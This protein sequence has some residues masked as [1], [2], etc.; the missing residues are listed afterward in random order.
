MNPLLLPWVLR[1]GGVAVILI[2][3]SWGFHSWK[4]S[5]YQEGYNTAQAEAVAREQAA[6]NVAL[7]VQK[8]REEASKN[9][10]RELQ[11]AFDAMSKKRFDEGVKHATDLESVRT[12]AR[13]GA[14][15]L[16]IDTANPTADGTGKTSSNVTAGTESRTRAE[17]LPGTAEDFI[18]IAGDSA[19]DVRA[20]NELLN[21]Y[22]ALEARCR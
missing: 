19:E 3:L 12:A 13:N 10:D 8:Q 20:F 1:I 5:I 14:L 6:T 21:H 7:L 4:K 11:A 18:R 16:S 22:R 9:K 17:L 15:R 2:A